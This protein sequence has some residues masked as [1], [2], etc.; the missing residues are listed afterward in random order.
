[1]A[2]SWP[3]GLRGLWRRGDAPDAAE[4]DE[5][6]RRARL[7]SRPE[8]GPF[9]RS[10]HDA[11]IV[12]G[13]LGPNQS[14]HDT[15]WRLQS[16]VYLAAHNFG[17][18]GL[19]YSY[20]PHIYGPYS[21]DLACDFY[22]FDSMCAS[23]PIGSDEWKGR[24]AFLELARRHRGLDW[25][26]VA[27]TLTYINGKMLAGEATCDADHDHSHRACLVELTYLDRQ[28]FAR[29]G[30]FSVY[31]AISNTLSAKAQPGGVVT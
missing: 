3:G 4:A 24:D 1:M 22:R 2:P 14:G 30:I 29:E 25:L 5:L 20:D 6:P 8:L 7:P 15:Y 10:L 16:L 13:N 17:H 31:D 18:P 28:D 26:S 23:E 9:M 12:T 27:A 19:K 21:L 11:G